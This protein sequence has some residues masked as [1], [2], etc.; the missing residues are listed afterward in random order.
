MNIDNTELLIESPARRNKLFSVLLGV[1]LC[2]ASTVV[3]KWWPQLQWQVMLGW[4]SGILLVCIGLLKYYEPIYSLSLTQNKL[5]YFHRYGHWSINWLDISLVT[6]PSFSYGLERRYIPYLGIKL[7]DLTGV[8]QTVSPR[9]ASRQIHEQRDI[10]ALA[11]QQD[12][13][14]IDEATLNLSAY[15]LANNDEV[16]GPRA[17]WLHQMKALHRAYGC[18]LYIPITSF[19]QLPEHMVSLFKQ[20]QLAAAIRS[21]SAG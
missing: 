15:Q 4:L 6:Q 12:L 11:C 1:L 3:A 21:S 5:T 8:V 18:D 19:G 10:L 9:L 20:Y 13:I 14:S 2:L 17:A 16:S 7:R